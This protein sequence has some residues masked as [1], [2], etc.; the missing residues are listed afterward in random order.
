MLA[1]PFFKVPM[2][3]PQWEYF[4]AFL[5]SAEYAGLY[6]K[7]GVSY[8]IMGHVHYRKRYAEA[9]TEMICACLGYRKEWK[10]ATAAEEIRSCLQVILV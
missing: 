7:Y 1:H 2:P 10:H 4:N 9:G 5:G 3:H 6:K 8:G